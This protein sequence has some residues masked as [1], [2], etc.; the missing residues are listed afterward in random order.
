MSA[1]IVAISLCL[2]AG[3]D[4]EEVYSGAFTMPVTAGILADNTLPQLFDEP[5]GFVADGVGGRIH[6][7]ALKQ[8]RP[9]TDDPTASFVPA[10]ALATGSQRLLNSVVAWR[11]GPDTVDV[12]ATDKRY[13]HL[14]RIPYVVRVE[15]L[16]S[17]DTTT[18]VPREQRTL[19]S[20]RVASDKDG[21]AINR[22]S[23]KPFRVATGYAA[24]EAWSVTYD[25]SSW[26]VEGSRSG[27]QLERAVG[28]EPY[29]TEG[30]ALSFTIRGDAKAGDNFAFLTDNG[31]VEHTTP[32][33][34]T[35]LALRDGS[36]DLA[37]VV[38][39]GETAGLHLFD[40]DAGVL[41]DS[42]LPD[43]AVAGRVTVEPGSQSLFAGDERLPVLWEV[44]NDNQVIG[45]PVPWPLMDVTPL[46][47]EGRRQLYL[48]PLGSP[49]VWLFDLDTGEVVDLNPLEAGDQGLNFA[50][51]VN[52]IEALPVKH[53][54]VDETDEGVRR[55][56][57]SVAVA[58]QE[59]KLLFIE[60][61]TGCLMA[62]GLGPRSRLS[63]DYTGT[64][65]T[66]SYDGVP[67][68]AAL[69]AT[70]G[71]G[72]HV[73]VYGCSGLVRS[74]VW[75]LVFDVNE[76]HWVVE[77]TT[78]GVQQVVAYEDERYTTDDGTISFV[79][80][81][82]SVATEDGWK[83]QFQVD[84]GAV[85]I[86]G[87]QDGDGIAEVR[88]RN[89]GD[90]VFFDYRVG[91]NDGGWKEVDERPFVLIPIQGANLVARADPQEGDL[92]VTWQ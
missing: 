91:P 44:Q 11:S 57:R 68:A 41:T 5:V 83:I 4:E 54:Y 19:A 53:L 25:G 82:G 63:S 22:V 42:L 72:R 12:Y 73:T 32:G 13:G 78:S 66:R 77:G 92:D 33:V 7:L 84:S 6:P 71:S 2:L 80:R 88:F 79:I 40:L 59:G 90:P 85:S 56:G 51:P 18:L 47:S 46:F 50:S 55:S 69:E 65:Y 60:E 14:L 74:Q 15:E 61:D 70:D 23:M 81:S 76:Q 58:L 52:G 89:P 62:D 27:R 16:R 64:D 86:N 30:R 35:H 49:A 67:G 3:C 29:E 48:V 10:H 75:S 37:V 45:H 9:L 43:E 36:R 87:D 38:A 1:R 24:S 21:N 8:G 20:L 26:V 34:P 17:D 39:N 28:G 31:I